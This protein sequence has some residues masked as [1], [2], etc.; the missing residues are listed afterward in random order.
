MVEPADVLQARRSMPNTRRGWCV[1]STAELWIAVPAAIG[2]AAGYGLAGALQ[3]TATSRLPPGDA[4]R[5]QL[6]TDLVRQPLWLASI[7]ASVGGTFLQLL[8]LDTG[9]LVMVEPLLVT[10]LL[11]AVV[12]RALLAGT[13]PRGYAIAGAALSAG[14]LGIFLALAQPSSGSSSVNAG[15]AL[16]LAAGLAFL[17]LACLVVALRY[18]G[19]PRALSCALAGGVAYGLAAGAAKVATGVVTTEGLWPLFAT[20]PLYAMIVLGPSGFL[21]NQQAY[22]AYRSI[23][24][25]QAVI[26]LTDPLVGIA[27]GVLWLHESLHGGLLYVIGDVLALAVMVTGVVILAHHPPHVGHRHHHY[28]LRPSPHSQG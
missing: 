12:F 15:A 4:F 17:I 10:G 23:A 20:W 11:F 13:R 24:P 26:T 21:L 28:P 5:P 2:G 8:A 7:G 9:P 19:Q 1:L 3:H 18:P 27:I 16:P 22:Q 25:T 14:G 6:I